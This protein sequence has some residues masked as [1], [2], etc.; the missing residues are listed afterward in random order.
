MLQVDK[1]DRRYSCECIVVLNNKDNIIKKLKKPS[2]TNHQY[3]YIVT[4]SFFK[5]YI[6][7]MRLAHKNKH[8]LC[9]DLI[10][11]S[12]INNKKKITNYN[13]IEV[14]LTFNSPNDCTI[15]YIPDNSYILCASFGEKKTHPLIQLG[16]T[17]GAKV[18]ELVYRNNTKI[19]RKPKNY[20]WKFQ[21]GQRGVQEEFGLYNANIYWKC[22]NEQLYKWKKPKWI[23]TMVTYI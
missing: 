1:D 14:E 9:E 12:Y 15:E 20:L 18:N 17:E 19:P 8:V 10:E 16:M 23:A 7:Q 3:V 13:N 5:K 4:A 6:K 11:I 22:V 2:D 21:T